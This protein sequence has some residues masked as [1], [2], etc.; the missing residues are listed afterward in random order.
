MYVSANGHTTIAKLLLEA[1]A[2]ISR[3]LVS[4]LYVICQDAH[5]HPSISAC[6]VLP[7]RDKVLIIIL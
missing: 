7:G 6:A 3:N 2:P 1:M 4:P 5:K